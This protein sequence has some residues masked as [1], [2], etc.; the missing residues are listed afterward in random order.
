V[1]NSSNPLSGGSYSDTPPGGVPGR[2]AL[3][4]PFGKRVFVVEE[5]ISI[6]P[7]FGRR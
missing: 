5:A 4:R 2:V 1:T 7:A 6:A 3:A